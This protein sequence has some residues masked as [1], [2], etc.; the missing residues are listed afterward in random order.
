MPFFFT[1]FRRL[2]I[3]GR[4]RTRYGIS[5]ILLLT[6]VLVGASLVIYFERGVNDQFHTFGDGVWWA[7][8]TITTVGYGDK[9]P[10]SI[11]GRAVALVVMIA[12]IGTFG[13]LA[14]SLLE[15]ILKRGR[16]LMPVNYCNHFVVCDYSHK[17]NA[18]VEELL[19]DDSAAK[20]VLL[21]DRD[22]NPMPGHEIHFVKGSST[23]ENALKKANIQQARL[24]IVL[25]ESS[26]DE[27]LADSHSV[28]TTL[29]VRHLNPKA[30]I[31]AEVLDPKNISH[32]Q[33]A[34]AD[35]I[36][37]SG[38]LA[39]SLIVRAGLYSGGSRLIRELVTNKFGNEVYESIVPSNLKGETFASAARLVRQQ[40][41]IL[42]GI[43]RN[44]E[45]LT[46]PND[47]LV[48]KAGDHLIYIAQEPILNESTISDTY[49]A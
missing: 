43:N 13:Y 30:K 11:G 48:I 49:G 41:G 39:S 36:I 19:K 8:V 12:G 37:S 46:N 21:A 22:E 14:G 15:D 40:S 33:R 1:L 16:G 25:A 17:T 34:G 31:I 24:V 10:L 23:D 38:E 20:I 3:F 6:V 27:S 35:E 4:W 28:L 42:I 26:V 18:I 5:V 47:E 45:V 2:N 9:F 29:A 7:L 44:N 32:F